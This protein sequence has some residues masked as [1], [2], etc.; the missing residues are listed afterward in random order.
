MIDAWDQVR[1]DWIK[2]NAQGVYDSVLVVTGK[3]TRDDQLMA[4]IWEDALQADEVDYISMVHGGRQWIKDEWNVPK[5]GGKLRMVYSEACQGGSA[6]QFIEDY[7]A[8]V[9]AGHGANAKN[10]SASPLFSFGFLRAWFDGQP[11]LS[12]LQTA[13]Q[14]GKAIVQTQQGF[15][16]AKFVHPAYNE[17]A[18]VIEG[19]AI[20]YAYNP[21]IDPS[22]VNIRTSI[23]DN[24]LLNGTVVE[25][26]LEE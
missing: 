24:Y 18:D 1:A 7:H 22:V 5:K 25:K 20:S 16:L 13:W 19:S 14:K 9:T 2:A 8:L 17:P 15:M 4:K 11:F 3:D 6:K 26:R 23:G 10:S 21:N 12:A